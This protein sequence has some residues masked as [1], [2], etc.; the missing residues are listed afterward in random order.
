VIALPTPTLI[1]LDAVGTLFGLKESVGAVYARFAAKGGIS[2]SAAALDQAFFSAFQ[3]APPC[4][5]AHVAAADRPRAEF[6][7]WQAVAADTFARAGV[8]DQFEDFRGFFAPVFSYYATAAPWHLY[9][10]VS[11][12]L[13]LWH[14]QG[15]PLVIISNF[16]SRLHGLLKQL[17]LAPFFSA[18]V[19]SS[20]VGAAKPDP[21]IFERA[22]APYGISPQQAW[23]IG[24]SWQDDVLGAQAA[25]LQP[26]WLR[27]ATRLLPDS[28]IEHPNS[29]VQI[30]DLRELNAILGC[31]ATS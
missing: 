20:E 23:H 25:Q 17:G 21:A 24:D 18:V 31:S 1:A 10:E 14:Q 9:P 19:I 16:D 29:V 15:I 22:I 7:W 13:E 3:A 6:A 27:R 5:F 26:I 12:V 8:L 4:A 30:T 2:V 28:G 11:T